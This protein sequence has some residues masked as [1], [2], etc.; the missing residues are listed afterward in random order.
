MA[1]DFLKNYFSAY[2]K[3]N[4]DGERI[5]A[6]V[7]CASYCTIVIPLLFGI[8]YGVACALSLIRNR[9]SEDSSSSTTK[10]IAEISSPLITS[11][12]QSTVSPVQESQKALS[13]EKLRD[14]LEISINARMFIKHSSTSFITEDRRRFE[15][16][17]QQSEEVRA[18]F[19]QKGNFKLVNTLIQTLENDMNKH[20]TP[21]Y[22]AKFNEIIAKLRNSNK[23]SQ[24]NNGQEVNGNV[25]E[26]YLETLIQIIDFEI[27]HNR[28]SLPNEE[29]VQMVIAYDINNQ[30]E[31]VL[32]LKFKA[33][34]I[35]LA[36]LA[37]IKKAETEVEQLKE[38]AR[39]I[40]K[41]FPKEASQLNKELSD[42]ISNNEKSKQA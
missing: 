12:A 28:D 36:C 4:T 42:A 14:T 3:V 32:K 27:L 25:E 13:I 15:W 18:A 22:S 5:K 35:C 37:K 31:T 2:Q 10:R 30:E 23:Q 41:Q 20:A 7:Q 9:F 29:I 19:I 34:I 40:I 39:Q 21:I 17:K 26:L 38:S 33:C 24:V 11:K 6:R 8:V 1:I 16:Y